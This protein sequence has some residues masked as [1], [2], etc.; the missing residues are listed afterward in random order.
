ME[1]LSQPNPGHQLFTPSST[2]SIAYNGASNGRSQD[3]EENAGPRRRIARRGTETFVA[4]GK[5]IRWADLA[6]LKNKLDK[7][8]NGEGDEDDREGYAQGFRVCQCCRRWR[9]TC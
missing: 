5:E 8:K 2:S 6:Y 1:W 3:D 7:G 4:V 9:N